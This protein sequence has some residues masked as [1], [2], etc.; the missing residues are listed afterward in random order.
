MC[1]Y[2]ISVKLNVS[3]ITTLVLDL[4]VEEKEEEKNLKMVADPTR[5]IYCA[6]RSF[7]PP[8]LLKFIFFPDE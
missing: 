3:K 7:P 6:F 2:R 8:P 1:N 5:D 4:H